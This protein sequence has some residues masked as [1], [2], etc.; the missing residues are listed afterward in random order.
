MSNY[1]IYSRNMKFTQGAGADY[2]TSFEG[3][4]S[5]QLSWEKYVSVLNN[6]RQKIN[7]KAGASPANKFNN[8]I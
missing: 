3:F 2:I 1:Q 8:R 4:Y 7:K 6:K 5:F